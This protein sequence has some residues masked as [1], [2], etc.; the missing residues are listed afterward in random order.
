MR[1]RW[2]LGGSDYLDIAYY[3]W[4]KARPEESV[5]RHSIPQGKDYAFDHSVLQEL[6][7][8]QDGVFVAFDERFGNFKRMELMQEAMSRGFRLEAFVSPNAPIAAET[9]IGINAFIG[10]GTLIG[11][12]VK[13]DY[14]CVIGAGC[15]IGYGAHIKPSCW[16]D[17]SVVIGA[18]ATIGAHCT[19][20]SGVHVAANVAVG[21]N[22]EIAI[23]GAYRTNI[24]SRTVFDPRYDEPIFVYG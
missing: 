24:A 8:A 4:K 16:L 23:P 12:A 2:V 11:A 21:R 19:L 18:K 17:D 3:A 9:K 5:H 7:P 1:S 13:I 15:T 14:N 22:C 6:D 10:D 20:R